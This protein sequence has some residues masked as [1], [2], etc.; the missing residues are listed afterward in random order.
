MSAVG[1]QTLRDD[2]AQYMFGPLFSAG[3]SY[4]WFPFHDPKSYR[5]GGFAL[6]FLLEG[7]Y[8]PGGDIT[9]GGGFLGVELTYWFG[10]D[11]NKLELPVEEAF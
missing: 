4:D 1:G 11:K 10:L 3:L 9:T 5:S 7:R 8:L 2:D 6:T